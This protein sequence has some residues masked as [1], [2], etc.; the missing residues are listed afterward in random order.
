MNIVDLIDREQSRIAR[1]LALALDE[2][3][4][5]QSRRR[6]LHAVRRIAAYLRAQEHVLFS[7]L[8][9]VGEEPSL[10]APM[11]HHQLLKRRTSDALRLCEQERAAFGPPM[12][13][14]QQEMMRYARYVQDL[15]CPALLRAFGEGELSL[16]GGEVLLH[17]ARNRR[18]DI[19]PF[20]RP[21][22]AADLLQA[23][24]TRSRE[25]KPEAPRGSGPVPSLPVLFD[26]VQPGSALR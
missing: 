24:W 2:S 11:R 3:E 25:K 26:V 14:L 13:K 21:A 5:R 20:D 16:L 1:D 22:G 19:T 4:A 15:L 8:V 12:R 7:A 18:P 9:A 17:L 23:L 10:R 6:C